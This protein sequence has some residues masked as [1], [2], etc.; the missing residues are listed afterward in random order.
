[1]DDSVISGG[2]SRV[3]VRGVNEFVFCPRLFHLMYVEGRWEE[4]EYTSDGTRVHR[5]V[6][7]V[8]HILPEP[9]TEG[10][11]EAGKVPE[12]APAV[13]R[14]VSV[15]SEALGL[16]GKIDL[17][18]LAPDPDG[19]MAAVPVDTKRGR[20]PK[21]GTPYDPERV[22]LMA[23]GFLLREQGY[24]CDHGM[25]YFA[26]SRARLIVP[27]TDEL[28]EMTRRA[29]A[30]ARAALDRPDLPEPLE[31]D[32]RCAGCSLNAI[33]LPDETLLMKQEAAGDSPDE[34]DDSVRRWYPVRDKALPLYVQDHGAYVRKRKEC[35]VVTKGDD[36]LGKARIRDV[37]QLVLCGRVGL[38]HSVI[39]SLCDEGIPIVHYSTGLWFHGITSGVQIRNSFG[40]VAQYAAAAD[41]S[42]S[43]WLAQKVVKAKIQNSRTLLR[44]NTPSGSDRDHVLDRLEQSGQAVKGV[45]SIQELLGVEG[46]AARWYFGAFGR[47]LEPR[48]FSP[49]LSFE[50]RNRRPPKD[51]INALLSFGYA[52]L[53][54]EWTVALLEEGLD[55]WWGMY[56]RPRHGRPALA[57]DLM[58]PFRPVLVDSAVVTAVNTGM[59]RGEHFVVAG[60]GCMLE[61]EGR[62][63]FITAYEN[64]LEQLVTHPE[65]GYRCSWR[66]ALRLQARL[67][68]RWLRG[69]VPRFDFIVTR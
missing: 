57:L 43:L 45:G 32:P 48:G 25:L 4:N 66:A 44:R 49:S 47:M 42:R 54:K 3:A 14:S 17:V 36:E 63:A 62:R 59:V 30:D 23:Q 51:P 68:A 18:S 61:R 53:V 13:V 21:E 31:E 52:M 2:L 11:A 12:D 64:R 1:M 56:H 65:F 19:V 69:D 60:G 55:P 41:E 39:Q 5:R 26:G 10:R 16:S 37:S 40:R 34:P 6:D 7:A 58:E 22:Q 8:E 35:L 28:E 27:F 24:R 29:I 15:T 20:V 67:F 46:D 9:D 33:C 50:H 38:S